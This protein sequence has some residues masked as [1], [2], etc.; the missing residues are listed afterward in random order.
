MAE[1]NK[2]YN[3]MVRIHPFILD[4]V[5]M[6]DIRFWKSTKRGP[7]PT[8]KGIAIKRSMIIQLIMGLQR[9]N[10]QMNSEEA[11]EEAGVR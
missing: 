1:V 8:S 10:S 2:E 7:R 4:D 9:V 5:D 3:E 6:L 11:Q